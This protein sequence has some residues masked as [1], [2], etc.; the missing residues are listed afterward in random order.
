MDSIRRRNLF[1]FLTL[2]L[3]YFYSQHFNDSVKKLEE[4]LPPTPNVRLDWSPLEK[5]P[6]PYE[7][8]IVPIITFANDTLFFLSGKAKY[9]NESSTGLIFKMVLLGPSYAKK[10]E[11]INITNYKFKKELNLPAQKNYYS[12]EDLQ[13]KI[14]SIINTGL[15]IEQKK[16]QKANLTP[17]E[18]QF[19]ILYQKLTLLQQIVSGDFYLVYNKQKNIWHKMNELET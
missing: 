4:L 13:D 16:Q 9:L 10:I 11:I 15:N 8:R 2:S 5:I 1:I 3:T 7:G 17:I 19:Y 14:A 6:V 12:L 18:N